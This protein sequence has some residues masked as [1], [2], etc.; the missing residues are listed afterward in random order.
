MCHILDVKPLSYYD[1]INR[2]IHEQ[3]IHCN[4]CELLVRV[5]HGETKQRYGYERLHT[6]LVEQGH[7]ISK[8]MVRRIKETYGIV[9]RR[10]QLQS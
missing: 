3:Q 10:H 9:C 1:W 5:A 6:H 4:Q 8:Y 2:D 7:I